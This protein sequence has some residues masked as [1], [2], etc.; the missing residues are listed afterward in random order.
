MIGHHCDTPESIERTLIFAVKLRQSGFAY[1]VMAIS[2]PFPGTWL[3]RNAERLR[4][5]ITRRNWSCYDLG[6]PVHETDLVSSAFLRRAYFF[7]NV[8][9][10]RENRFLPTLTGKSHEEY[11]DWLDAQLER[12]K[13]ARECAVQG[14]V[15]HGGAGRR[16]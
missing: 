11:I 1:P 16:C 7:F 8:T 2:T 6:T 15:E 5:R 14:G 13:Q 9:S 10:K 4:V 12:V 3:F